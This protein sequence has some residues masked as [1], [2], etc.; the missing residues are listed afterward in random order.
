M[1]DRHGYHPS[2]CVHLTDLFIRSRS[3]TSAT[4]CCLMLTDLLHVIWYDTP[5]VSMGLLVPL[6]FSV[7]MLELRYALHV[8]SY[9]DGGDLGL[10]VAR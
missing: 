8:C 3:I 5:C 6:C 1:G 9:C 2:S 4:W 7:H 10:K